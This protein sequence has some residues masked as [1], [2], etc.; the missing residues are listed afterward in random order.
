MINNFLI[1]YVIEYQ[2][3]EEYVSLYVISETYSKKL[4]I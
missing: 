2:C 3:V 4:Y 1:L